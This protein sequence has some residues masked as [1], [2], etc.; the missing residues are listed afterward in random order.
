MPR[1]FISVNTPTKKYENLSLFDIS[2][3]GQRAEFIEYLASL[4][5][6]SYRDIE[7]LKQNFAEETKDVLFKY[8]SEE[9]FPEGEEKLTKNVKKGDWGELLTTELI[10][11]FEDNMIVPFNKLMWKLNRQKSMFCTDVFAHTNTSPISLLKYYEVKTYASKRKDLGIFAHNSLLK[12][13][14]SGQQ[15]IA[16]MLSR[17]NFE[18]GKLLE[19]SGDAKRA[20]EFYKIGK[21]YNEIVKRPE[22]FDQEFEIVLIREKKSYV[23]DEIDDLNNL[24]PTF[25]PMHVTLFLVEN[26]DDLINESFSVAYEKIWDEINGN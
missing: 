20:S 2:E 4:I 6:D 1:D 24:P 25:S 14:E 26:L 19:D 17:K 5:K 21:D 18:N 15:A 9:V 23:V 12:D 10:K 11:E 7:Y 3:Q 13:Q 8:L 16:D 22:S